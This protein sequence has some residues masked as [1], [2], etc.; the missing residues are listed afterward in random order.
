MATT[1]TKIYLHLILV[2][3]GRKHLL[4]KAHK[5]E[6]QQVLTTILE[7]ARHQMIA[8]NCM[9]DH[10]HIF[11]EFKPYQQL[12]EL[13][14]QLKEGSENFVKQQDWMPFAFKWQDGFGV[15]T[16]SESE[17]EKIRQYVLNQEEHHRNKSFREEYLTFLKEYGISIGN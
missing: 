14:D 3:K 15:F 7:K 6:V 10:S 9:P 13:V 4:P 12:P 2:V 11:I 5:L 8:I 16:C 1:Y 17:K